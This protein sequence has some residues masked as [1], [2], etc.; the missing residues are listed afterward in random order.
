MAANYTIRPVC[1]G[2]IHT[3]L[4]NCIYHES[5]HRYYQN[6]EGYLDTPITVF[7]LEGN[8]HRILVDT[9]MSDTDIANRLH[10]KGS[11]QPDG[12]AIQD[13]I[14]K[15]GMDPNDIDSII[16]THMHWDH[17][18][19]IDK[20]PKASIF[21]QKAEWDFSHAPTPTYYR[22]YEHPKWNLR[23]QYQGIEKQFELVEGENQIFP[24]IRVYPSPGHSIGHQT[25][26]VDTKEGTYHLCGDLIFLYENLRPHEDIVYE[27]TPP[28]RYQNLS[29]WWDSVL[30]LKRRAG[31]EKFILPC[32][33]LKIEEMFNNGKV[34]GK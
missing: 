19:N 16:L 17:Y 31:N 13:Q 18:Y 10:I 28:A 24:G 34:I 6:M 22:I 33:D 20:F 1:T 9:G 2:Y 25:V 3:S 7:L 5:V 14:E 8:G 15:L 12:Y 11:W 32:H 21:V 29:A 4:G 27:L 26:A 23:P 30:E